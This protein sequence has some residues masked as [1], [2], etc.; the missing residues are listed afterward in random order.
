MSNVPAGL[1]R[2]GCGERTSVLPYDCSKTGLKKGEHRHFK[3]GHSLKVFRISATRVLPFSEQDIDVMVSMY[4]QGHSTHAIGREFGCDSNSVYL[5]LVA[6]GVRMRHRSARRPKITFHS[7]GYVRWDGKYVHRIVAEAWYG[8]RLQPGEHI[9][10]IDGDKLNNHPLNLR[11]VS[12]SEHLALHNRERAAARR[13]IDP[14]V[15]QD[16]AEDHRD[17][18]QSVS[19][20]VHP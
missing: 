8:R 2:C 17:M 15:R 16:A 10:H 20:S 14:E 19:A 9:H 6:R 11:F 18:D 13:K 1:C 4:E 12:A 5:R 7:N 3:K